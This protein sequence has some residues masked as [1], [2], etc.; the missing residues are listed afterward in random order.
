MQLTSA[1]NFILISASQTPIQP[2]PLT[3]RFNPKPRCAFCLLPFPRFAM[4]CHF[5]INSA[6]KASYLTHQANT[7]ELRR[8]SLGPN[9]PTVAYALCRRR[10][11]VFVYADVCVYV[12]LC[13]CLCRCMC[14]CLSMPMS[15]SVF[16]S[17]PMFMPSWALVLRHYSLCSTDTVGTR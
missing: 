5:P 12:C 1:N 15:M 10:V 14:L 16:M 6:R 11:Y 13:L 4:F 9:L 7:R 2:G 8:L 3:I 17:M